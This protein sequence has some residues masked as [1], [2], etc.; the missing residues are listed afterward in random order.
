MD[1]NIQY[2]VRL[3]GEEWRGVKYHGPSITDPRRSA[4]QDMLFLQARYRGCFSDRLSYLVS[5]ITF[6]MLKSLMG[7]GDQCQAVAQS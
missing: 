7:V 6:G 5:I 2:G 3:C 1:S 4:A